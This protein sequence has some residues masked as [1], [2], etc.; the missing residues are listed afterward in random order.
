MI[1]AH[2]KMNKPLSASQLMLWISLIL[3]RNPENQ[4][5]LKLI[6][7]DILLT[8]DAEVLHGRTFF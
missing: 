8:R 6:P 3:I 2:Q 1:S 7:G 4:I 5:R